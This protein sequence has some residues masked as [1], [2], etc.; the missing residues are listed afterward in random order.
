M[1]DHLLPRKSLYSVQSNPSQYLNTVQAQLNSCVITV[2]AEDVDCILRNLNDSSPG[3]DDISP[4]ALR[5]SH[6]SI[7]LPLSRLISMSLS[8]GVFP[9]E[10][11]VAKVIPLFKSG[12]QQSILNYRPISVLSIFSKIFE[13]VVT[14]CI[15][16]FSDKYNILCREQFGFRKLH[17]TN[18]A[19]NYFVSH[20]SLAKERKEFLLSVF[21]DLSKAF[22]TLNHQILLDKLKAYGIRG[23]LHR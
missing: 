2:S 19:L 12:D 23:T 5:V 4:K 1:S 6:A 17:S 15:T 13:T 11:K 3:W 8:Q 14:K 18:H 22:D 21:L 9:K 10:L 7:S 20:V 16:K